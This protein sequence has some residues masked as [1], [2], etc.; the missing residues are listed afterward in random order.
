[1]QRS[2]SSAALNSLTVGLTHSRSSSLLQPDQRFYKYTSKGIESIMEKLNTGPP[3]VEDRHNGQVS[4][5][6][7]TLLLN[8][9][10][11]EPV[12]LLVIAV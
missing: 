7:S 10:N 4:L 8:L 1:V 3:V 12:S 9:E 6:I 2:H 5:L 11:P